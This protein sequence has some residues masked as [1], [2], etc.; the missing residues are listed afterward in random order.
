[1]PRC[2]RSGRD[3]RD[4]ELYPRLAVDRAFT[5]AGAGLVVTGTLV[6]GRIRVEDRLMLSPPGIELRVRGLHA[7]NRAADE[8][9]ARAACRAE[10]HRASAVEGRCDTR[11]LG[12]A[13]RGCT[14]R[15]R[16]RRAAHTARGGGAP[17]R[18]GAPVHLHLGAAHVMARVALLDA[19]RI[20]PGSTVLARLMLDRPIGALGA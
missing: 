13:S 20:E 1:M 14:R 7:Q 2:W 11:R 5:L 15:P 19:D 9:A 4:V 12:A 3:K 16:A 18:A 6:A 8:A 10:R 17:L